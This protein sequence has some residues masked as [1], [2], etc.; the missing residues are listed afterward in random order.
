MIPEAAV[1][2][3]VCA[4][5]IDEGQPLEWERKMII[6]ILEA[7]APHMLAEAWEEGGRAA[8]G[9]YDTGYPAPNPYR[10]TL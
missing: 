1:E 8:T 10:P 3:A 9:T 6:N 2:A 4:Y 7:A 5:G